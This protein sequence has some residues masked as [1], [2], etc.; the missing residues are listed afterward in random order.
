[1]G[2]VL[3]NPAAE[4]I[5]ATSSGDYTVK[6]WNVESG[7]PCLTLKHTDIVQSLSWSANGSLI[8][9]TSRDKKLRIWDV[10]Q[11]KAAHVVPGHTGAKNSRVAWMGELDRIATTGFSRMSDR[12]LGLWD[13]RDPKEPIGGFEMLDSISGVCMP[14][15]DDSTQCLYLAGKGYDLVLIFQC[16]SLTGCS[17]GNIRYFEYAHDKF[18]FLSEYKSADPQRGVAFIP[19][20]GINTHEN[21]VMRAFKTVNDSYI[22]P[23][24]FIVPRRAEVFQDDI[25]PPVVGSKPAMS[26]REWFDG[27]EGLPAKIDLGSIYAGEEPTEIPADN[28]PVLRAPVSPRPHSPAKQEP[29]QTKEAPQPSSSFRGPPPSMK[30]QT[31]SIA[32]LASKFADKDEADSDDGDEETSSFEEVSKPVDRSERNVSKVEDKSEVVALSKGLDASSTPPAP[33]AP[34]PTSAAPPPQ[35]TS[36]QTK[37]QNPLFTL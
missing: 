16:H 31:S 1:M 29:E 6:I 7:A 22:E 11:E 3:F 35:S 27:N 19:K 13:I 18:E 8:V 30:E 15:W 5:L 2:H 12:Q 10:R 36:A 23:I 4:N 20:R 9:T 14:F 32:N 33:A 26:S 25:Y 37:V 34:H 21:E 28:K 17:D 24:S